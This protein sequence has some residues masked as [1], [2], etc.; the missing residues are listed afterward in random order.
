MHVPGWSVT[1]VSSALFFVQYLCDNTDE[2]RVRETKGTYEHF[3]YMNSTCG[4]STNCKDKTIQFLAK[5]MLI[6]NKEIPVNGK[7]SD[8]SAYQQNL[9]FSNSI[10]MLWLEQRFTPNQIE[11]SVFLPSIFCEK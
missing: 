5:H 8:L 2:L 11:R 9:R 6:P 3:C 4:V 7:A 10:L 1:K